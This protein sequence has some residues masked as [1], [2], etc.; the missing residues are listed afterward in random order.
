[1]TGTDTGS[2][3]GEG[4][5]VA[6][7]PLVGLALLAPR[8]GP[9]WPSRLARFGRLLGSALLTAGGGFAATGLRDLG[10]NLTPLPKP[11][12]D[13]TLVRDGVY[14]VVRHPIY[15]GICLLTAGWALLTAN[16]TRLALTGA[17]LAFFDA[18][19]NREEAWLRAR[20]PDYAAYQ[21]EVKKLLPWLY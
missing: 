15:S 19:A 17:V 6:Q 13:A 8:L 16:T 2:G 21:R 4:W 14:G 11:K 12:D 18:K 9:P 1:M 7:F 5:V 10:A 3:R 20:F